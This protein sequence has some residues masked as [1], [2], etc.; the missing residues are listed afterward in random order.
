MALRQA[1]RRLLAQQQAVRF[2]LLDKSS[3]AAAAGARVGVTAASS[4]LL[5]PL[6]AASFHASGLARDPAAPEP[7]PLAK[8]KDS[9]N[10]ATSVTYLEELEQRYRR[11]P[12]SVDTTWASFFRSLGEKEAATTRD[13]G[14]A[15]FSSSF[16]GACSSGVVFV[17]LFFAPRQRPST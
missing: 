11:D 16:L 4:V 15:S 17:P 13:G 5:R 1:S 12:R 7:V 6:A 3:A 10:D 9:F 14:G 8:L 2:L